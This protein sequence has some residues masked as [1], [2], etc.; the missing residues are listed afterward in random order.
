MH[1]KKIKIFSDC[2]PEELQNKVNDFFK[3]ENELCMAIFN[4]HFLSIGSD[5]ACLIYYSQRDPDC[6]KLDF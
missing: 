1:I 2:N 4:V 5:Y 6:G 3:Q